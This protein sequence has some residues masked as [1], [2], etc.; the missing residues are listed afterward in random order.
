MARGAP[1]RA[2]GGQDCRFGRAF[3][4]PARGHAGAPG[5]PG[6]RPRGPAVPLRPV[7]RFPQPLLAAVLLLACATSTADA[8]RPAAT[9]SRPS[10]VAGTAPEVWLVERTEQGELYSN[11]LRIDCR[12]AVSTRPRLYRPLRPDSLE[13]SRR[14]QTRPAGI[15]Y[16]ASEGE[17]AAFAQEHSGWIRRQSLDLLVYARRHRL[18]HYVVD[19]FGGVHRIVEESDVADHAGHSVWADSDGV[20][21]NLNASFLG[22]SFEARSAGVAGDDLLSPAQLHAGRIL[23]DLLRAKYRIAPGNCI[24]HAQVSVNPFNSYIGFHSDWAR[25]FP[26]AALGLPDRKP[27]RKERRWK[28]WPA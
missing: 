15:V 19:R 2:S 20:Y 28:R 3:A 12:L 10:A 13:R 6:E 14:W 18:Y 1:H 17:L 5:E 9:P 27:L 8:L 11:G 26:F 22:V 24:T 25:G 21:L 4:L 7:R 16:H 23:T